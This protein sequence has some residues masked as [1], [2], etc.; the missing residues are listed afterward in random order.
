MKHPFAIAAL[1]L[2]LWAIAAPDSGLPAGPTVGERIATAHKAVAAKDWKRAMSE[3]NVA[4]REE[5]RNPEVHNLL[6][7]TYRMQPQRNLPKSYE[8]YNIALQLNPGHKAALEYLGEAYLMDGKPEEAEKTLVR[9]EGVC[10]RNCPEYQ[11]LA[12]AIAQYKAKK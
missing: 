2:P 10:G 9:L 4:L 6:G 12:Q 11:E 7:F 1:A 5:P 3:L 8:H